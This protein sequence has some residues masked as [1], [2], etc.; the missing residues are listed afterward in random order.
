MKIVIDGYWWHEGPLSNRMV[1]LEIVRHWAAEFPEDELVLAVPRRRPRAGQLRAPPEVQVVTSH[2]RMHPAI[3]SIELPMIAR[4]E[5]ADAI[6]AFNFAA[7][8]RRGV[9]FL[10]DVLFQ[11]NPEWFTRV[12]RAYFSA[13][14][15]LARA[16]RSVI[17][18]SAT[19]QTR[20]M[21]K[22][23]KLRRVVRCGLAVSSS[24][25]NA[26]PQRPE[27]GLS[28][29]SF[30]VCVGRFNI[31]KNLEVTVRALQQSG[32]LS[33]NF[34]LVLIGE[35]SG[36]PAGVSD[37]AGAIASKSIVVAQRV[38]EGELKWLYTNCRFFV[39]LSLDEGFGLPVIEAASFDAPVLA[40]DIAV[41]RENLGSYG[42]YVRPTDTDAVASAARRMATTRGSDAPYIEQHSWR[43]VCQCIRD[44]LSRVTNGSCR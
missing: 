27:L 12:E 44:E 3:N 24:L 23:P 16:A 13:M 10:H 15:I 6:L 26:E 33:D 41:F 30:I 21:K 8:S 19:E 14:P 32:V 36:A 28:P 5:S 11:T 22:N 43:S 2:L 29:S 40:S 34:P 38:S 37:F 4:R 20:I 31:R 1:L 18:T 35:P 25:A 9:V 7:I 17:A 39:C 42:T